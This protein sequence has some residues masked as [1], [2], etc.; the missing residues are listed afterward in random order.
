[1]HHNLT[2]GKSLAKDQMLYD[3]HDIYPDLGNRRSTHHTDMDP[4]VKP[5]QENLRSV[6][7]PVKDLLK[8]KIVKLE[9]NH[10]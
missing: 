10:R 3:Y 6:P 8:G 1:M 7:I 2:S 5:V 4:N 9:I